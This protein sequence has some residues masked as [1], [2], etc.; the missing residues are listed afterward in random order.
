MVEVVSDQKGSNGRT[1]TENTLLETRLLLER[2]GVGGGPPLAEVENRLRDAFSL[3]EWNG[4]CYAN[5]TTGTENPMRGS[6]NDD[7]SDGAVGTIVCVAKHLC[8]VGTD[9]ALRCVVN[10]VKDL[11]QSRAP[12][13]DVAAAKAQC[14]RI[15]II[16]APCC[17]HLCSFDKNYVAKEFVSKVTGLDTEDEATFKTFCRTAGWCAGALD[18]RKREIGRKVKRILDF[19][20]VDWLKRNGFNDATIIPY[21]PCSLTPENVAIVAETRAEIH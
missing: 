11:Q 10:A 13:C 1:V 4:L 15:V 6:S 8:G 18:E 9:L 5:Y 16:I 21:V 14:I 12:R 20:R 19:G 7:N 2:L 17:H 3:P